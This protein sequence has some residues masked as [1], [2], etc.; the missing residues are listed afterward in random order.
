[1]LNCAEG[2]DGA[3]GEIQGDAVGGAEVGGVGAVASDLVEGVV[4][5]AE[6]EAIGQGEGGIEIDDVVASG[7]VEGDGL[8]VG[9][10]E[11]HGVEGELGFGEIDDIGLWGSDDIEGEG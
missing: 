2:C 6:I 1:M 4:A 3:G 11:S 8:N 5:G 7:G 9:Q 10:R